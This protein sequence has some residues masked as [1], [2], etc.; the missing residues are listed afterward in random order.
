MLQSTGMQRVR[1]HL[2]N[3]NNNNNNNNNILGQS[4]CRP[5]SY[6]AGSLNFTRILLRVGGKG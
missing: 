5:V 2:A 6:K 1:H 4:L 3:N